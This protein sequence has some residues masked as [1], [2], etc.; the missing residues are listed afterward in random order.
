[1]ISAQVDAQSTN[2]PRQVLDVHG[3]PVVPETRPAGCGV[4]GIIVAVVVLAGLA[5]G[6]Y[7]GVT[8]LLHP[9][10]AAAGGGRGR[11]GGGPV[12]V[13][14]APVIKGNMDLYLNGLGT[15]TA[16]N[17]VTLRP[18]VDGQ[19]MAIHFTEGQ[20]VKEGQLLIEI[21]P[22]PYQVQLA[23]AQGQLLKD[24]ALE[25]NAEL[26]LQRY[27]SIQ[28]SVTQQQIDTQAATVAQYKGI[29]ESDKSQVD[30]ANLNLVYCKIT[31]PIAGRI[32]LRLV[33]VGNMVHA[34]DSNGLL[35]ITQLQ[36]IS[37]IFTV[38]EDQITEVLQ[39]PDHGEG[40]PVEAYNRDM[41][42]VLAKGKLL[43]V[44][45]QV[46]PATGTVKLKAEFANTD[47][48]LFPNEFVNAKLLVKTLKDVTIVPAAAVQMGPQNTFVYVVNPADK[49]VELRTV[50][51]GPRE[52]GQE[53]VEEGLKPGELVV[54]DGVD[55]LTQG[56]AVIPHSPNE[57]AGA[58]TR[59]AGAGG[60]ANAPGGRSGGKRG[61]TT[62]PASTPSAAHEVSSAN[63]LPNPLPE[64]RE[65][66]P[67][68]MAI[69]E[70]F[71][72][73]GSAQ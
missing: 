6:G 23:Q 63:P 47:D 56:T 61:A 43:A 60:A 69:A 37:M 19:I 24:Q 57:R 49:K 67:A 1:M 40:L 53:V 16:Y 44:D 25:K 36:P 45:N 33:D 21:D 38:S 64:Y 42:A 11:G 12:P 5:V 66:E 15:V 4:A 34:S 3:E 59:P 58:S 71:S 52:G 14:A 32:G 20:M 68:G 17:T 48:S 72:R 26:D 55:K 46:D 9:S 54:T 27:Q 51:T 18:R 65:R 41:T 29:V 35:V 2:A 50:K 22:R 30:S 13:V 31:A 62:R 28:S 70:A 7:F 39:R 73:G 10:A 8:R